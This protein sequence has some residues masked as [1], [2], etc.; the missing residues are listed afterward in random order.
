MSDKYKAW[1]KCHNRQTKTLFIGRPRRH[2]VATD[3]YGKAPKFYRQ[4][5]GRQE[6]RWFAKMMQGI[7]K[8][9]G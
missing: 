8:K 5:A 9:K 7:F 2:G 1:K 4:E 3:K 6:Q